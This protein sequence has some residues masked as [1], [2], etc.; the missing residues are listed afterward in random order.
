[1]ILQYALKAK[2]KRLTST[3]SEGKKARTV[4]ALQTDEWLQGSAVN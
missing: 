2:F 1:M 4:H 3:R